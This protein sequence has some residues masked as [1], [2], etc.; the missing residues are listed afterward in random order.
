MFAGEFVMRVVSTHDYHITGIRMTGKDYQATRCAIISKF[1]FY[2][3]NTR[4]SQKFCNICICASFWNK[5]R[6]LEGI[7]LM[8]QPADCLELVS[9]GYYLFQSM[10]QLL[11][12]PH[13]KQEKV[14]VLVKEFFALKDKN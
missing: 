2:P 7:Q 9:S 3:K 8:L 11:C 1:F 10:A 4:V 6:E 13:N 5:L 14:E 12:S